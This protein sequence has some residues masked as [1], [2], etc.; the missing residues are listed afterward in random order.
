MTDSRIPE[1]DQQQILPGN[2]YAQQ[3]VYAQ[4]SSAGDTGDD[5]ER[6]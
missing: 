2:Y 3:V 5:D 6:S 4:L 1:I